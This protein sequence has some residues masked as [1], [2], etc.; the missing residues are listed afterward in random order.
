MHETGKT[1]CPLCGEEIP[2][3]AILCKRCCQEVGAM[4][5]ARPRAKSVRDLYEIVPLN[6]KFAVV[7]QG[8]GEI[9]GLEGK[10][11]GKAQSVLEILIASSK[12]KTSVEHRTRRSSVY[13][14][15]M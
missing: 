15:S 6:G 14:D 5:L 8:E 7:L 9:Y 11:L 13:A 3:S 4:K 10:D 1:L 2:K 12:A